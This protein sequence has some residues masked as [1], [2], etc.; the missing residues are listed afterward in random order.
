M[1]NIEIIFYYIIVHLAMIT[2]INIPP[3]PRIYII[4]LTPNN[5]YFLHESIFNFIIYT[6]C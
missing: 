3:R 5:I 2:L 4:L 6:K 1:H